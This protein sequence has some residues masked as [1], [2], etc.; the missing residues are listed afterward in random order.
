MSPAG[1]DHGLGIPGPRNKLAL[2]VRHVHS[3]AGCPAD[4]PNLPG[5]IRKNQN[6]I[7][8]IFR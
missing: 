5:R 4:L 2:G 1:N 8:P 3:P 6:H 7:G